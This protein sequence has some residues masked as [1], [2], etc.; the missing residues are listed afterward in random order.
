MPGKLWV[1]VH[2]VAARQWLEA[3][4]A[5]LHE[6]LW[7]LHIV[8]P[9]GHFGHP[10]SMVVL[11]AVRLFPWRVIALIWSVSAQRVSCLLQLCYLLQLP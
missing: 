3:A 4:K 10:H 1:G 8:S 7:L 6:V 5:S 9:Q 2:V 11:M